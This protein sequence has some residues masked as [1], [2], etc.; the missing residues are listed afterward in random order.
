MTAD[1]LEMVRNFKE[2]LQR[3]LSYVL[4]FLFWFEIYLKYQI[5]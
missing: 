4:E 3:D 1:N 5:Y 2:N